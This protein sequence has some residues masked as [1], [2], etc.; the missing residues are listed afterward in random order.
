MRKKKTKPTF[1]DLQSAWAALVDR[2]PG[3]AVAPPGGPPEHAEP[4]RVPRCS[5]WAA[6]ALNFW[7][8]DIQRS[9]LDGDDRRLLL[10]TS[11]QW[12]K[13]MI[14][15]IRAVW[16]AYWFPG[17]LIVVVGPV[18]DQASELNLKIY[19]FVARLGLKVHGGGRG[20]LAVHFPNGSRIVGLS[21]VA[22]HVRG[23]SAPVLI[24]V[25]EAAFFKGDEI[26]EAVMPMLATRPD[27]AV[28]IMST[29]KGHSGFFYE[30][31]H[32]EAGPWR[33][34][35]VTAAE[36]PHRI[37]ASF[38]ARGRRRALQPGIPRRASA[39]SGTTAM[40]LFRNPR[41]SQL[42]PQLFLGLDL[43]KERDHTVLALCERRWQLGQWSAALHDHARRPVLVLRDLI[44]VPL[45]TPYTQVPQLIKNAFT[46]H[47][48]TSTF[49]VS[50]KTS[51]DVVVDAGGVGGGVLDIIRQ[52]QD[53]LHLGSLQLVPVFTSSGH[54]PGR[55]ASGCYTVPKRDLLT[56]L[57]AVVEARSLIIP[58]QLALAP[59]LFQE[60]AGLRQSGRSIARHDDLAMALC[61]AVWWAARQ[62]KDLLVAPSEA[63]AAATSLS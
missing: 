20:K 43:G 29:P 23:L 44:R 36:I 34:V 9:I 25:D 2:S 49:G 60:L 26:L 15:A 18:E 48:A 54:E 10:L 39:R 17:S 6:D 62:E 47:E 8:D 37:P 56:A 11:R 35:R 1:T 16:Q 24:L 51:R 42:T 63:F 30:L 4:G 38:L 57:R 33:R 53:T 32:A 59:D 41:A 50:V 22:D 45:N 55:T 27:G 46:R 5:L 52:A 7:P 3:S 40:N 12:G 61:L 28:W 13:S 14:A 19:D 58:R 21:E 31:W